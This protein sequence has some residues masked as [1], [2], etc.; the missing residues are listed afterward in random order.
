MTSARRDFFRCVALAAAGSYA[1][2]L[3]GQATPPAQIND[4]VAASRILAAH[5]V[6]D[7]YGHVS[8]RND[9]DPAHYFMARA[10]AP[11]LVTT[12]DILEYDLDSNVV[13]A[14]P[15]GVG[16]FLERFIHGEIYKARPDVK[17]D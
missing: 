2:K 14:S 7:A 4:L 17:A 13:P 8:V 1:P 5:D 16:L 6:F 15:P 10:L 9:R 11:A 12:A 3:F